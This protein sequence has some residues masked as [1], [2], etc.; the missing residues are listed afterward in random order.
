MNI[1]ARH[2]SP[3]TDPDDVCPTCGAYV[4]L[5]DA[6][7][8]E[9]C[10]DPECESAHG[11][12]DVD[13]RRCSRCKRVKPMYELTRMWTISEMYQCCNF[14]DCERAQACSLCKEDK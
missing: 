4:K 1:S 5:R 12:L 9:A 10:S 2:V 8:N 11:Y 3:D 7:G 13:E 14:V 6:D